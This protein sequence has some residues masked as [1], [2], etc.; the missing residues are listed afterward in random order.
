MID[1][2]GLSDGVV[3]CFFQ[4]NGEHFFVSDVTTAVFTVFIK[5]NSLL[6]EI[7][8]FTGNCSAIFFI[9]LSNSF[10]HS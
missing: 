4:V 3:Y 7:R 1:F 10:G 2:T 6:F 5:L 9:E 8:N